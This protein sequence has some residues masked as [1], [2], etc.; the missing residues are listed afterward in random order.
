MKCKQYQTKLCQHF[1]SKSRRGWS[2]GIHC[3]ASD[4]PPDSKNTCIWPFQAPRTKPWSLW[5]ITEQ[6]KWAGFY[7]WWHGL[8][9]F[10]ITP[11]ILNHQLWDF[12]HILLDSKSSNPKET[13][14]KTINCGGFY[15]F[16]CRIVNKSSDYQLDLHTT[17]CTLSAPKCAVVNQMLPNSWWP[18]IITWMTSW[19][20]FGERFGFP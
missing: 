3:P 8:S 2:P 7:S 11:R 15:A 5:K 10:I 16:W 19:G 20:S 14:L 17:S 18:Y 6:A 13:R 12:D 9:F 4:K 1:W